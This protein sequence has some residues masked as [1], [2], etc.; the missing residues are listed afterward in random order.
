MLS[1]EGGV[2]RSFADSTTIDIL[3]ATTYMYYNNQDAILADLT[4]RGAAYDFQNAVWYLSSSRAN[5]VW[6]GEL[7]SSAM[8]QILHWN[9]GRYNNQ[10]PDGIEQMLLS[11]L[12]PADGPEIFWGSSSSS[13]FQPL[14][15]VCITPI[16]E[17]SG[18]LLLAVSGALMI[19]RRRSHRC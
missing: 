7:D 13:S 11:G 1:L 8:D 4:G 5:N 9:W 12:T 16:P 10:T 2:W 18:G 15:L 17:P 19:L 6:T 14:G 3:T